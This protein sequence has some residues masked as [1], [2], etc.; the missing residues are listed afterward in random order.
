MNALESGASSVVFPAR[1]A[2]HHSPRKGVDASPR[3]HASVGTAAPRPLAID[4]GQ[5][6]NVSTW[7]STKSGSRS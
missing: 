1:F 6:V 7:C 2:S 4:C 3:A 5:I